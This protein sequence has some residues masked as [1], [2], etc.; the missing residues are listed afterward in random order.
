V[1]WSGKSISPFVNYHGKL[2]SAALETVR[3]LAF[4]V[5]ALADA[6][7]REASV[8]PRFLLHDS[9]READLSVDIYLSLFW[10]MERLE[11]EAGDLPPFQYIITTTE[12]PPGDLRK[13]RWLLHPV[14]RTT[15][16]SQRFLGV[17]L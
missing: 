10:L 14:L 1:D 15:E 13:D 5:T 12:L 17:A 3:L 7:I 8:L 2:D 11:R 9:P 4:D 6:Y 16:D